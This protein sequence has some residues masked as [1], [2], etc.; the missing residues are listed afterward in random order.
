MTYAN[1][2]VEGILGY[3]IDEILASDNPLQFAHPD[4]KALLIGRME[5]DA[6]GTAEETRFDVRVLTKSGATKHLAVFSSPVT[7]GGQWTIIGTVLDITERKRAEEALK[8][9]EDRFKTLAE[10][11]PIGIYVFQGNSFTYANPRFAEIMGYQAKELI[12]MPDAY[13]TVHADDRQAVIDAFK[14]F[15]ASDERSTTQQFRVVTEDGTTRHVVAYVSKVQ[16]QG[17]ASHIGTLVDVTERIKAEEALKE[18]ERTFRALTE[19]TS[20]AIVIHG[21]EGLIYSNPATETLTG[22]SHEELATIPPWNVIGPQYREMIREKMRQR[23]ANGDSA[24]ASYELPIITKSGD[25]KWILASGALIRY[26]GRPAILGTALD[27]TASRRA[28]A[29]LLV[30]QQERYDQVKQIAG[31]VAHEIYNALFPAVST[32][33]KLSRRLRPNNGD[34][35]VRNLKLV[36]LAETSVERAIEMTELVAQFSRLDS[37]K[38]IEHVNLRKLFDEIIKDR[39][40][41]SELK[42]K[43]QM[44]VDTGSRVRMNRVHAYSLFS[45]IINNAV[46][47]MEDVENRALSIRADKNGDFVTVRISDSGAGIPAEVIPKIF[48]PFFS[49]KPR[50]GTGLGL[51]ICKRIV[52]IYGGRISVDSE[53]DRGA[54]FNI[55]LKT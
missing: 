51:A 32:L 24:V 17:E 27:I 52:D 22:Y 47:A 26:E 18:S 23:L 38:D 16:Y 39:V 44:D 42:T 21:R 50:R 5:E 6:R 36:R 33:D 7:F 1:K 20:A 11:S 28:Q 29:E 45:N 49:T 14:K 37:H 3:S 19:T 35:E 10:Q 4:D 41:I 31:G 12:N 34:Q 48:N 54:T 9:S 25:E 8:E 40:K 53:L 30:A 13:A 46:D 55:L 43:V 15:S 2:T